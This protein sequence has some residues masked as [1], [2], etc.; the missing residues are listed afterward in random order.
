MLVAVRSVCAFLLTSLS[1]KNLRREFEVVIFVDL[2]FYLPLI[3][4][5]REWGAAPPA[6][7]AVKGV[8]SVLDVR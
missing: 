6:P 3:A 8:P 5:V 7:P 1:H 2:F 4:G